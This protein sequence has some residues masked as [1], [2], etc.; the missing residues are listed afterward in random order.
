[1]ENLN[2][3]YNKKIILQK[4]TKENINNDNKHVLFDRFFVQKVGL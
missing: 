2:E 1:M 3:L 4:I